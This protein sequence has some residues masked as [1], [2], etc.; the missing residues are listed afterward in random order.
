MGLS[1]LTVSKLPFAAIGFMTSMVLRAVILWMGVLPSF[2]KIC[3]SRER[4]VSAAWLA[5]TLD[6]F[7]SS[8]RPAICSKLLF[9]ARASFRWFSSLCSLGSISL[10]RSFLALAHKSLASAKE[11]SGYI[12]KLKLVRTFV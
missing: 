11:I 2:G 4:H 3:N 1:L 8:Q 6:F 12:P 9:W 7:T 10:D 5:V